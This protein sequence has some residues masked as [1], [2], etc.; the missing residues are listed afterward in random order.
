MP[1]QRLAWKFVI[2]GSKG[3]G[4]SSFISYIVYG[5][6]APIL[7][8]SLVK[9]SLNREINGHKL[10]VDILFQEVDGG[11]ENFIPTATAFIIVV[12]VTSADSLSEAR[13]IIMEIKN[14]KKNNIFVIGN[15]IDLK[16][17]AQIWIDDMEELKNK[18]ST[19]YYMVSCKDGIGFETLLEDIINSIA[20][21][22]QARRANE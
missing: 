15:K 3:A 9:K 7:P 5:E 8:R 16:Y 18:F 19:K 11:I 22:T 20:T 4:K 6:P 17:E 1:I 21:K 14:A 12:D 10:A 2:A 13:N